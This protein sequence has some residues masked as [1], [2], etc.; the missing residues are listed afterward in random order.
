MQ[1][2]YCQNQE[3]EQGVRLHRYLLVQ[4]VVGQYVN[5]FIDFGSSRT[6]M[7]FVGRKILK[8]K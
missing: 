3:Q 2:A 1:V 4:S 7:K 8:I 6:M 5:T